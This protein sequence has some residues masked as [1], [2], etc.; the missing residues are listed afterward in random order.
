MPLENTPSTIPMRPMITARIMSP[1]K[2]WVSM[3]TEVL[4]EVEKRRPSGFL[5]GVS[6]AWQKARAETRTAKMR[7]PGGIEDVE[8]VVLRRVGEMVVVR[9]VLKERINE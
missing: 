1:M 6:L 5:E 8:W 9:L 7:R 4:S 2:P 3:E